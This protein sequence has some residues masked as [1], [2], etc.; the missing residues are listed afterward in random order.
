M[1]FISRNLSKKPYDYVCA[2]FGFVGLC[3]GIGGAIFGFGS[4][5]LI[6]G[7]AIY[8]LAFIIDLFLHLWEGE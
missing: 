3:I 4:W 5:T 1:G 2:A 8:I 6:I 7:L